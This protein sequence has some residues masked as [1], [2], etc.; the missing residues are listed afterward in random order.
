[1]QP[2]T[3]NTEKI[4]GTVERITFHNP[5]NGFS[6]LRVQVDGYPDLITIVGQAFNIAVGE[7][8]E[9]EGTWQRDKTYGKQF[10]SSHPIQAVL[11]HTLAGM[12]KYLASGMIRGVG[13][14]T[15]KLLINAF[16]D[17]VFAVLDKEP[18][19]L[20]TLPGIGK[21]RKKQ[22]IASW[23]QQQ[24]IQNTMVFLQSYGMSVNKA[25]RIHKT[26]GDRAKD[27]ITENPYQLAFDVQGIG[28]KSAD[29]LAMRLGFE[30]QSIHRAQAGIH[31]VLQEHCQQG[32][33]AARH[34]ALIEK[35]SELLE[36]DASII[37]EAINKEV[38]QQHLIID[39]LEEETAIFPALFYH[40]ELSAAQELIRLLQGKL[41]WGEIDVMKAI[42]WVEEKTQLQLADSQKQAIEIALQHKVMI[43]TGGPGVGKTTIVNSMLYMMRAKRLSVA[44]CA[45]T[46][47]AAK[48]LAESTRLTAKTIHRLLGFNPET[49][50]FKHDDTNPLPIDVLII[51][52][53]SMIDILLLHHLL[54]A[55]PDHAAV[56]FLGDVDQLP[57]VG[58]GAILMDMIRSN[59]IPTVKLTEIFRQAANSHIILN[60]HRIN[61]GELPLPNDSALSDFFTI[62]ADSPDEIQQQLLTLVTTRI[63][64]FMPC[65]PITDIQI[66]TPMNRG[67]LGT[68]ALNSVLQQALNGEAQP[69]ISRFGLT[70][71]PGDKVI[72]TVNNYDKDVF[73]GDIG[74]IAHI[75]LDKAVVKIAFDHKIV[76]YEFNE[77]DEL[78]LAYAISIHKSQGSEFPIV[79][80]IVSTQHY[81][82]LAKNLLYTGVTRGKRLVILLG[83]KKAVHIAVN[84]NQENKRLTKL[85]EHLS[86]LNHE[87]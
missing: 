59:I 41:P 54:K 1:M 39:Q 26:Y 60:A 76:E 32:H 28:F 61:T 24:S 67:Q 83:S 87:I 81:L 63:P 66:L 75:D 31:H 35:C 73:N 77:L 23:S 85:A 30:K 42:P 40:A 68:I 65:N 37:Q 21:K 9:C 25:V 51:D 49:R 8:I 86:V 2:T 19:K 4:Q 74:F 71:S 58:S 46:G 50:S 70:Y 27:K 17:Q 82:M 22:I 3:E 48:R 10:K 56:F 55:V 80:I 18:E 43:I 72:Q 57:S 11:P 16:G 20:A 45:P 7:T 5:E 14:H 44:L 34:E 62:Y 36:I 52:E 78:S 53:A 79:I 15:A 64:S 47:R 12:E 13:P 84:N 38:S 29:E 33:C 6:V 69:K